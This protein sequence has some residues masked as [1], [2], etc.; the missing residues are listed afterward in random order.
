MQGSITLSLYE[1]SSE[2]PGSANAFNSLVKHHITSFSLKY[3]QELVNCIQ[4]SSST[5]TL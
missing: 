1:I 3:I 4:M 5:K 2:I